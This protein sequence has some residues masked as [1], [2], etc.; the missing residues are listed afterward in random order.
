[1]SYSLKAL[2]QLTVQQISWQIKTHQQE[3][4]SWLI[5]WFKEILKQNIWHL[6]VS[7]SFRF[8]FIHFLKILLVHI[9][10]VL[11]LVFCI[12]GKCLSVTLLKNSFVGIVV[13]WVIELI[14]LR[15]IPTK[16]F[17]LITFNMFSCCFSKHFFITLYHVFCLTN[18]LEHGSREKAIHTL[19]AAFYLQ[20]PQ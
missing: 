5:S 19:K 10:L 1:M 14:V 11:I 17:A 15:L 8:N 16:Y 4:L 20:N 12:S 9:T 6:T 13:L 18:S 3:P 2:S 7:D